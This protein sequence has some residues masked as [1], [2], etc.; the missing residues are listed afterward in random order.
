MKSDIHAP[1]LPGKRQE[2]TWARLQALILQHS[3]VSML[4]PSIPELAIFFFI[5][6]V[7]LV[8][9]RSQKLRGYIVMLLSVEHAIETD[10][11]PF[12]SL[13]T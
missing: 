7:I 10:S 5:C 1:E 6:Q 3:K 8:L 4:Q 12:I 9:H 2:K 13:L 11:H